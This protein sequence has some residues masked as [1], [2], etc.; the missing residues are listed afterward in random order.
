MKKQDIGNSQ[1]Q[2]HSVGRRSVEIFIC[3]EAVN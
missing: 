1:M 3:T 2:P